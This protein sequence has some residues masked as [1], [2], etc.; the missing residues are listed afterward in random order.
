MNGIMNYYNDFKLLIT[1]KEIKRKINQLAK[2]INAD[3]RGKT[4]IL[5]SV[6][7]GSFMFLAD[8]IRELTIDVE[9]EFIE[10]SSY[11]DSTESSGEVS[12]IKWLSKEIRQRDIILVEDIVDTGLTVSTL[13]E[14]LEKHN[15]QSLKVCTLTSKPARREIEVPI[16]YLGFEVPNKFI[17][18]YGIDYGE[19]YRNL[20][21]IYYLKNE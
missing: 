13:L 9:I 16:H 20:S 11:G 12:V 2:R 8:L 4:P 1:Q 18:G 21:E 15:P 19:K 3:Y 14:R 5:I 7:K 10:L 17:I 6:L